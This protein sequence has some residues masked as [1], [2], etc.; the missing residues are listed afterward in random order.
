MLAHPSSPGSLR[1]LHLNSNVNYHDDSHRKQVKQGLPLLQATAAPCAIPPHSPS[2]YTPRKYLKVL[3][4]VMKT[5]VK[6]HQKLSVEFLSALRVCGTPGPGLDMLGH[7]QSMAGTVYSCLF[8]LLSC[9]QTT[10]FVTLCLH[11]D[12]AGGRCCAFKGH[13]AQVVFSQR[14][15][16]LTQLLIAQLTPTLLTLLLLL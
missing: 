13:T 1:S 9:L 14:R 12:A 7:M 5:L 3:L 4:F 11:S 15:A 6:H 2:T 8:G 16:H 10:P